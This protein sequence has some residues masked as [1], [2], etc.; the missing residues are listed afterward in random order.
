MIGFILFKAQI[1]PFVTVSELELVFQKEKGT[2]MGDIDM[3]L[4]NGDNNSSV[5]GKYLRNSDASP[6]ETNL[7]FSI[8][9]L[10]Q[11]SDTD[12]VEADERIQGK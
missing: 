6:A 5:C 1:F 12:E 7:K 3:D 4:G 2:K 11:L 8:R 10:L 9:N